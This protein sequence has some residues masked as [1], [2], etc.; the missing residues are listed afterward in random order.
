[1][2]DRLAKTLLAIALAGVATYGWGQST[3]GSTERTI[4][5]R[6]DPTYP[7]LARRNGLTG[8][9]KLKVV[10]APDGKPKS[11][12]V[13]GGN[14]VFLE[15]AT[16]SVKKWKWVPADHESVQVVEIRFHQPT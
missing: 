6:V 10:I 4:V 14:P 1:M 11:V 5:E 15:G 13:M 9:V 7:E 8:V 12:E 2:R 3:T 16:G